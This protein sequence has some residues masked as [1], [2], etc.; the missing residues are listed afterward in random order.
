MPSAVTLIGRAAIQRQAPRTPA[1]PWNCYAHCR[2]PDA[3]TS[4]SNELAGF[5]PW[6]VCVPALKRARRLHTLRRRFYG[7][8]VISSYIPALYA[9][10]LLCFLRDCGISVYSVVGLYQVILQQVVPLQVY[11]Q[12]RKDEQCMSNGAGQCRWCRIVCLTF[13]WLK[14]TQTA[15]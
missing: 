2:R 11:L 15:C 4:G 3:V 7:H 8:V 10:S 9:C 1:T 12:P 5:V 6:L 14:P 13:S